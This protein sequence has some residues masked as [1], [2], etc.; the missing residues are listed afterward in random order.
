MEIDINVLQELVRPEL[1][2]LIPFIILV[3]FFLKKA[4]FVKDNFIPTIL[5]AV[6]IVFAFLYMKYMA[7]A[8]VPVPQIFILAVVQG[9]FIAAGAVFGNQQ[10]KQLFL[11]K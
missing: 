6:A 4:L 5:W 8:A 10:F 3:G 9:T 1:L 7:D 2:V 11:K